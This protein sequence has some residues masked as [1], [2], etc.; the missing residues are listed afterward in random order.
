MSNGKDTTI[1]LINGLTKK[2]LN[3]IPSYKNQSILP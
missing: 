1:H 2:T 3:E